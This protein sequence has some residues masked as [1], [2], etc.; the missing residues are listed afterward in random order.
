MKKKI[1]VLLIFILIV[2][3]V[4]AGLIY[5]IYNRTAKEL[6]TKKLNIEDIDRSIVGEQQIN[7]VLYALGASKL[8]NPPLSKN[9]PKIEFVIDNDVYSVEIIGNKFLT[10]KESVEGPD[11]RIIM[12]REEF[13]NA[14]NSNPKLYFQESVEEGKTEIEVLAGKTELTMKGYL[15]LYKEI[16]GKSLSANLI[17]YL[18]D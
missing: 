3:L 6:P 1:S 17:K 15:S 9:A 8:H 13:I 14:L 4:G 16:T 5:F 12:P 18:K 11:L 7:L 10:K 2:I